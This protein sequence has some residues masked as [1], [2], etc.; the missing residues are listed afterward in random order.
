[1]TST[2]PRCPAC[3]DDLPR[4]SPARWV[5][6]RWCTAAHHPGC[7]RDGCAAC[8]DPDPPLLPG[9]PQDLPNGGPVLTLRGGRAWFE[10][11]GE[12]AV[13]LE[14]A[15]AGRT[16]F[17]VTL[18]NDT[19]AR[20]RVEV[21]SASPWLS[22]AGPQAVDLPPGE[23]R[24]LRFA[25]AEVEH[26]A[27]ARPV[28]GRLVLAT[29]DDSRTVRVTATLARAV[30]ASRRRRGLLGAAAAGLCAALL[31]GAMLHG[32]GARREALATRGLPVRGLVLERLPGRAVDHARWVYE[33]G[34]VVHEQTG[35]AGPE[36]PG[37]PIDLVYLAER[38]EAAVRT[39][40]TP[41][42]PWP[43]RELF[44]ASCLL[45][46]GLAGWALSQGQSSTCT[47]I[48]KTRS[49]GISK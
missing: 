31:G 39:G 18:R 10:S 25:T 15:P 26:G 12:P 17:E 11:D 14:L 4:T 1:M 23:T 44:V 2:G 28:H 20:Q 38:P 22:C 35:V 8:G 16:T 6:C 45:A 34:E 47:P 30:V 7:W 41:D 46:V 33:V 21:R 27:G 42:A 24:A 40:E 49:G 32:Q 9:A 13:A 3:L 43:Q 5:G 29:E 19:G 48:S 36:R 37:D